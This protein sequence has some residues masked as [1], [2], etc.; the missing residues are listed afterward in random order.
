M[1]VGEGVC[2]LVVAGTKTLDYVDL[3]GHK[4]QSVTLLG[5]DPE[6]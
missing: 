6:H 2:K 4:E 3:T 5:D 1:G